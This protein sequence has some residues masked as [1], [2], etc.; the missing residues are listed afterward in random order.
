[1]KSDG[2]AKAKTKHIKYAMNKV[3]YLKELK[4]SKALF[5]TVQ[6]W[7]KNISFTA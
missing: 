6:R 7:Q 4:A 2:A 5:F 1:M 3:I